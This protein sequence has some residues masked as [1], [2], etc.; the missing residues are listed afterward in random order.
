M[1]D[2]LT[3]QQASEKYQVSVN[4]VRQ[5]IRWYKLNFIE[6]HLT[7]KPKKSNSKETERIQQL[8]KQ[9]K[10]AQKALRESELKNKLLDEIINIAETEFDIPVRGTPSEKSLVPGHHKSKSARATSSC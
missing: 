5:W 4:L 9:L 6:P 2:L 7:M 10:Q 8:A 3:Q 1:A